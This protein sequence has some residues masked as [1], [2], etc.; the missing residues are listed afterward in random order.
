MSTRILTKSLRTVVQRAFENEKFHKALMSNM[1]NA[2]KNA[3]IRLSKN[4]VKKL[5][6]FLGQRSIAKDFEVYKKIAHKFA[7]KLGFLPW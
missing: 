7:K 3:K 5:K 2:L 6:S 4:D 1:E